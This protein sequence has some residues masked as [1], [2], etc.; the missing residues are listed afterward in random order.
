MQASRAAFA[1]SGA[2][3]VRAAVP[4][5]AAA[6]RTR[7]STFASRQGVSLRPSGGLL[8]GLRAATRPTPAATRV[9]MA[10]SAAA[11]PLPA[12]SEVPEEDTWAVDS[13]FPTVDAFTAEIDAL[14]ELSDGGK[15]P[16]LASYRGTLASA[17]PAG[18]VA[19]LDVYFA[20]V[21]RIQ[22]IH[23]Y[24]HL[25]HD[26]DTADD[27]KKAGYGRAVSVYYSF[28]EATSWIDPELVALPEA[29]AAALV[30]SPEVTAA[31]YGFYLK[32]IMR[33]RAHTLSAEGEELIAMASKPMSASTKAFGALNNADLVFPS[34][35]DGQGELHE[36]TLGNYIGHMRS[37]DRRRREAAFKNLYGVYGAH[38]NALAEMLSGAVEKNV[39]TA[40]ARKYDSVLHSALAPNGIPT[41]VYTSL[42]E[43]VRKALPRTMH[44]YAKLRRRLLHSQSPA[45]RN[46][47]LHYWDLYAPLIPDVDIK[48]SYDEARKAVVESVAPLGDDYKEV[49]RAGLFER[50]WVDK[51]EK[52]QQAVGR[53]QQRLPRHPAVCAHELPGEPRWHQDTGARVGTLCALG[54]VAVD[55]ARPVLGLQHF[56]LLR[57]RPPSTRRSSKR[58]SA[59]AS[60]PT[61][62]G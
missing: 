40:R 3:A 6:S 57:W 58:L 45:V 42:V 46:F 24:G 55:A 28:A 8:N 54:L 30:D 47:Q 32:K 16:S 48:F 36:L 26:T 37:R 56:S 60:R 23:V 14:N 15:W 31:G 19:L 20:T 35:R 22:V 13:I 9:T 2:G 61:R 41:S 5:T 29:D 44:K 1:L 25:Q 18:V 7:R 27:D 50:R 62:S 52:R 51:F 59:R 38:E 17:G 49:I 39:F 10:V 43:T 4:A 53:V 12:R 33:A 34:F 11:K 21:R